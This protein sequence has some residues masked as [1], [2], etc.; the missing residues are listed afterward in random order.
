ML[1]MQRTV[2]TTLYYAPVMR[3]DDRFRSAQ[4][5]GLL[6]HCAAGIATRGRIWPRLCCL[7][8][9]RPGWRFQN[10]AG[11]FGS[12]EPGDIRSSTR[13]YC[14]AA[15]SGVWE[16]AISFSMLI[17][18]KLARPQ[19]EQVK[20]AHFR[21]H[22]RGRSCRSFAEMICWATGGPHEY[23]GRSM[24]RLPPTSDDHGEQ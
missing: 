16:K 19:A 15:I 12:L 4:S 24:K 11:T 14:S 3:C 21:Y 13:Q 23:T 20:T 7:A 18:R 1:S 6:D 2:M 5:L 10:E 8:I 17:Q 22:R 9:A